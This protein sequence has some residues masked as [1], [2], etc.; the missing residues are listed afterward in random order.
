MVFWRISNFASLSGIGAELQSGRWHTAAPGKCLVYLSEHPAVA[1]IENLVNLRGDPRFF[2][3]HFQLLKISS[4]DKLAAQELTPKQLATM[5][6][7]DLATTQILGDAWLTARTS[8][9]LRVPSIP[10]HESW[11]YL[12][13][14]LHPDARTLKVESARHIAYDRRLFRLK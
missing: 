4:P 6:A 13:N 1:L 8:A 10:S 11:N 7:E 12:L 14:P 9:L 2:Q 5:D 3:Q